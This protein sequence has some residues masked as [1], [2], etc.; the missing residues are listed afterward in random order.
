MANRDLSTLNKVTSVAQPKVDSGVLEAAASVAKDWVVSSQKAKV[1]QNVSG[2]QSDLVAMDKA[3]RVDNE[4][5]PFNAEANA[6]YKEKRGELVEKYSADIS[7]FF[8]RDFVTAASG[9]TGRSDVANQTWQYTQSQSNIATS[10]NSSMK[11]DF[12]Q[13]LVDGSSFGTSGD[14]DFAESM[15]RFSESYKRLNDFG[16]E[17]LGEETTAEML[18]DYREDYIKSFVSGV[19][20][21]NPDKALTLLSTD[22]VKK[23]FSDGEQYLKF[24]RS[25]EVRSE[26]TARASKAKEKSAS[27]AAT[28]ALA[29]NSAGMSYTELQQNFEKA[30]MSPTAQNFFNEVNGFARTKRKL[31]TEEK[32]NTKN[33]F[34]I[35]FADFVRND[36]IT[37]DNMAVM[38]DGVYDAMSKNILTKNEGFG[39]LNQILDPLIAKQTE[40]ADQF[41][42]GE[43]NPFEENLG[44]DTFDQEAS[45]IMGNTGS[46]GTKPTKQQEFNAK[47][48][49]NFMLGIYVQSLGQ[50][51]AARNT[52]V[53]GLSSLTYE[54]ETKVYNKAL[55]KAKS[56]FNQKMFGRND[57]NGIVRPVQPKVPVGQTMADA[58]TGNLYR[59]RGGDPSVQSNWEIVK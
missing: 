7:P 26:R 3:F 11:T 17:N 46:N 56:A 24:K 53:S 9:V 39:L 31:T 28:N 43:W 21:V 36:S 54:E 41:E 32:T 37:P 51:A 55:N 8:R 6:V 30:G 5:D 10:I 35:L 27:L 1:T 57:V 58:S 4:G 48:N 40:R 42:A 29:R 2:L 23:E 50:E 45:V 19:A 15:G 12:N 47:N 34:N 49:Y 13:A 20:D 52:T 25:V 22:E 44:L 38:Q 14:I 59:F 33:K 16:T 18:E